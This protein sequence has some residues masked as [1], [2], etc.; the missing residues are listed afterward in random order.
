MAKKYFLL[1][2]ILGTAISCTH[3]KKELN[4]GTTAK[5]SLSIYF[6]LANNDTVPYED[7][8]HYNDTALAI[9]SGQKNDS[10]N[11]VYFFKVANRYFNMNDLPS[12]K[13]ITTDIIERAAQA[14]DSVSLAKAYSY[15]GDYYN[16]KFV[17]DT[18]YQFYFK[19]EKI[20]RKLKDNSKIAK[21]LLNK[22]VL[23]FNEKDFIGSEKSAFDALKFLRRT[24]NE[25]MTYDAYNLLGVIYNELSEY[26]KALFY[27]N[28]AL[29]L[30]KKQTD[31]NYSYYRYSSLN[32]I[33]LVFQNS[34]NN[35]KA[36]QYFTRALEEPNLFRKNPSSYAY[37]INNMGYSELK[38]GNYKNL[39]HLFYQTLKITDSL[40]IIPGI[41][42]S[43]L[44]LS[45]YYA[46]K[47]DTV[48]ARKF[49]DEAY[50]LSKKSDLSKETLLSLKQLLTIDTKNVVKYSTE[51]I[52]INDSIQLAERKI[53]NKL[54]RI[55]FETEELSIEKDK[56]VEQRKTLIYLGLGIILIGVFIYVIRSQ[57][58]KNR[59]LLLIQEQ[60]QAN[61]EI[62]QLMLDQQSKVE[63][64]R[65][66]EKKKIA[67]ELHDAVLGKLFGTRMNLGVLNSKT[68]EKTILERV[69]FID[70][71]KNLEQEIREISHDLNSEKTAVFNNF[72]LMVGNF[73][74]TQ[75]PVCQAS[76]SFSMDPKIEWSAIGDTAKI[77]LYR[78]LQEAFQNINKHAAAKKVAVTFLQAENHIHLHIIDDGVGFNYNRKKKGIGLQNMHSRITG[79]DGSMIIETHVGGGTLLKFILP[80]L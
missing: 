75:R 18:A 58:A 46:L 53:R 72:V 77:N 8:Q 42:S 12:Y 63:E 69:F 13:K 70:E 62:Y 5:D 14:N 80:V 79:S 65:Q 52:R 23:Q 28:K 26:D 32:N 67:L 64:V 76:I 49:L 39:P 78:I 25:E 33:G 22:S 38:L 66:A 48:A 45:E 43:K 29:S 15:M 54:A 37:I 1:L 7:R 47:K 10:L 16:G 3:N 19:A 41:I 36:V 35:K 57:A 9:I 21:S 24:N 20:Y 56:L 61:E 68:D 73:I 34:N 51:Y 27:H 74:E 17:S 40:K 6:D 55:E 60:Q 44:H 11:R 59:E 2:L 31:E 4:S 71:L 50:A 30:I